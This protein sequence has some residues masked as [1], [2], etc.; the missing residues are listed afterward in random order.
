MAGGGRVQIEIE[1]EIEIKVQI[2]IKIE[3]EI[4][5]KVVGDEVVGRMWIGLGNRLTSLAG[6]WGLEW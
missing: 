1:I 4:K 3:I 6:V 2:K 5:I